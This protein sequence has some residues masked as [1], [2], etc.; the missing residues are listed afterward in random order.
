MADL[1]V[2]RMAHVLVN[3]SIGVKKASAWVFALP[4]QRARW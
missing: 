2:Q 4:R 3:Y 1:H